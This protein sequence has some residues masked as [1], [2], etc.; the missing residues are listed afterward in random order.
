MFSKIVENHLYGKR[1]EEAKK[2]MNILLREIIAGANLCLSFLNNKRWKG[3]EATEVK[4]VLVLKKIKKTLEER[5]KEWGLSPFQKMR[6]RERLKIKEKL[7]KVIL[8]APGMQELQEEVTKIIDY[9]EEATL[10]TEKE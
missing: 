7:Q 4:C 9:I 1:E 6:R 3:W 10:P 2:K 5:K 8:K